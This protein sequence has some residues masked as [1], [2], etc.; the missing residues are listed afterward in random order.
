MENV[1]IAVQLYTLRNECEKDF[2]SV[3][4]KVA[5]LGYEGVEFAGFYDYSARVIKEHLDKLGLKTVGSHTSL[6][7]LESGLDA[8]IEY[9]KTIENSFIICPYATWDNEEELNQLAE[10]LNKISNKT[11]EAGLTLLYHNHDHEFEMINNRYGLDLLFELTKESGLDAELDTHWIQRAQVDVTDYIQK[12]GNRCKLIHLKD[13]REIGGHKD[14]AAVGEG[15]M[16]IKG[17]IETSQ[18]IGVEWFV[19]ENDLP[20]PS[21]L[22]NVTISIQNLHK[23]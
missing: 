18:K 20:E 11:R 4:E 6:E 3:L 23:M 7:E 2:I 9:N 10:R 5:K 12:I 22:E 14:Y 19:V 15:I 1:K 21:G 8:I 16:D 17:I 13:L